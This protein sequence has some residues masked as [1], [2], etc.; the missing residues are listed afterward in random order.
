LGLIV[1]AAGALTC[2]ALGQGVA[3]RA[4]Q[5]IDGVGRG[6]RREAF[7]VTDAIRRRF[8][9]VRTDV[10]RMGNHSRVY[11]RIH[12]DRTL[13]GSKIEVHMLR[14]G[15]VL[16]RGTVPDIQAKDRAVALARDTVA[17]PAVVDELTVLNPPAVVPVPTRPRD[18]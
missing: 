11:S 1:A 6:V 13:H 8:D 17:V 14:D 18:R 5:A 4:G 15:S 12:W 7:V 2:S 10:H 9:A 16:L 3:E